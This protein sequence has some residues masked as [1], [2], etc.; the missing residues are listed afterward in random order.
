MAL[1]FD[2]KSDAE[3]GLTEALSAVDRGTYIEPSRQTLERYLLDEWLPACAARIRPTTVE[4]YR[5]LI[6]LH[7]VPA[8]GRVPLAQLTPLSLTKFY[9][10]LL[11]NGR[12]R[13]SGGLS[14]RTVRYVHAIIRKAMSDAVAWRLVATNPCDGAVPPSAAAAKS[15]EMKVWNADQV[16]AFLD[17]TR[18]DRDYITWHLAVS[19]GLRRGEVCGLR[20]SDLSLDAARRRSR[21]SSRSWSRCTG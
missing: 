8:I 1:R 15:P 7:V 21:S 4:S 14:P 11:T 17:F 13:G 5:H 19:C 6:D 20:W 10:T 12:V 18:D 16:R 2:T 9:G 3:R